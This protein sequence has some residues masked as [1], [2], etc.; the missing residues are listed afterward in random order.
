MRER[1]FFSWVTTPL[2]VMTTPKSLKII[3][4]ALVGLVVL[5]AVALPFVVDANVYKPRLE[6]AASE[7]LGTEVKVG[8][9]MKIGFFPSLS[10]TLEDAHIRNRDAD[11]VSAKGA[12][13]GIDLLPLLHN[14]V[15]I[16]KIALMHPTISIER[17]SDGKYNFERPEAAEGTFPALDLAAISL[18][19]ATLLYT[20]KQSGERFK[21]G[22]CGIEVHRLLRPGGESPDRTRKLSFTA[23]LACEKVQTKDI[24]VSDLKFSVAAKDGIFDVEAV[25]MRLFGGQGSGSIR[26]DFS[27]AAPHYRVHYSLRQ[28]RIEQFF[29]TLS[30]REA[31]EGPMDFSAKLSMRG[32]TVHEMKLT[33]NGDTS[34]RGNNLMLK[35]QDLDR[36]FSRFESSQNFNLVDVGAF[37]YSGPVGLMVT[38]GYNFAN[39]FRESGGNS[40][41]RTLV[42]DWKVE[43]GVAHAQD[44]AMATN[45]NRIALQGGLDFVNERFDDVTVALI[46][47]KGCTMVRQKIRG[48]FQKPVVEK[49][50]ILVALAGPTVRL[51]KKI[52]PGGKCEVFYAGAV[53][54]PK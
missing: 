28:F 41:I 8:G 13:L 39:L 48:P 40:D 16:A 1:S 12:R 50:N 9:R 51:L 27:G 21:A 22:D 34:L 23:E 7:V 20:D 10:V 53:V 2:I 44:V 35:G 36:D 4:G 17:G 6:A 18:S 52:F 31:A 49:P 29:K 38:K 14:E 46:D 47:N 30:P 26:A 32:K 43:R 24:T 19:G 42:S 45:E 25:T 37:F 11:I 15:R 54:P 5:I 33:A 3:L